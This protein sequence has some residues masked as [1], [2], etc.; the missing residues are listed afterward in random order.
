MTISIASGIMKPKPYNVVSFKQAGLEKKL[1][2][3]QNKLS[4]QYE[5]IH[6]QIIQMQATNRLAKQLED[7]Y[8]LLL[9][10]YEGE[11]PQHFKDFTK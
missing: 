10:N 2:K 7:E 6:K 5:L 4:T 3:I 8:T 11:I 1:T 9:T